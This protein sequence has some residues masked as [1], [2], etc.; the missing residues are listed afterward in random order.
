MIMMNL[1]FLTPYILFS[2]LLIFIIGTLLFGSLIKYSYEGGNKYKN[3]VKFTLYLAGIPLKLV[4]FFKTNFIDPKKPPILTKHKE[5][6]R[7]QQF[8]EN[9][10]EGLLV[11]PRYDHSLSRAVV[12]VICLN[13]FK[14]IHT[15]KHDIS[16]MNKKVKS[17]KRF[18]NLYF[19][20]NE[21]NFSY[22]HPLIFDD[23]SLICSGIY[24]PL[25]K[26]DFKSNLEWINDEIVFHH[27]KVVDHEDNIWV[28]GQL[29]SNTELLKKII[30]VK[31]RNYA[32]VKVNSKNEILFKKS[33]LE[34]LIENKI[35]TRSH[36]YQ[37]QNNNDL[38]HLNC[39]EP[40]LSDTDFWK[41]GDLFL[42]LKHFSSIVH[43]RPSENKIINYITGP[44][45]NQHDINILSNKEISILNN[46]NFFI[47]NKFSE[48]LIYNFQTKQFRTL[49]N[50]QLKKE[51]FKTSHGGVSQLLNDG[52]LVVEEQS[53]GRI[54]LFNNEGEKEWEFINKDKNG[55]IGRTS[56]ISIL[57]D[58]TFIN[59]F[60]SIVVNET[61]LN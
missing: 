50:E 53:H 15:Y 40:A 51:N 41:K 47:D 18:D 20:D 30:N 31:C 58:Q 33:I 56:S 22:K 24:S 57:E 39:I 38:S 34:I 32:I 17:T 26:I 28:P 43:Y 44:Y 60:K 16:K 55:N 12:D 49:F 25:F 36:I 23:G 46:N 27:N 42:S 35:L 54:M 10:R 48:V 5:K 6:K 14:T 2:I 29:T 21:T 7:F 1:E 52:S 59:K 61:K 11:L 19:Q 8:L 4:R 37:L 3:L 45:S 9:N 13:K